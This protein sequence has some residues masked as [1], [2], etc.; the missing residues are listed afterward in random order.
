MRLFGP[1]PALVREVADSG[2]IE[3][4]RERGLIDDRTAAAAYEAVRHEARVAADMERAAQR[5]RAA[6]AEERTAV[7]AGEREDERFIP[8]DHEA[9]SGDGRILQIGT[10]ERGE[11]RARELPPGVDERYDALRARRERADAERE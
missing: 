4:W 3:T 2:D 7:A 5:Q 1:D 10:N 9:H 8:G 11:W 6:A